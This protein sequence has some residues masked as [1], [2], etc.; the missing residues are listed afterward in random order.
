[1]NKSRSKSKTAK[2][3]DE[4]QQKGEQ[5]KMSK[6]VASGKMGPKTNDL[7]GGIQL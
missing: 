1:M 6:T 2:T 4:D 7:S 5:A 3:F